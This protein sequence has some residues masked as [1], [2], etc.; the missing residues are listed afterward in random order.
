[1]G[2]K[3]ST[4]RMFNILRSK[5]KPEPVAD[6]GVEV[7]VPKETNLQNA[8][9]SVEMAIED[10]IV[11]ITPELANK[12]MAFHVDKETG[13]TVVSYKGKPVLRFG[14]RGPQIIGGEPEFFI[15][16]QGAVSA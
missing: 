6:E 16:T 2:F 3:Y 14:L 7:R 15:D 4:R 8:M 10:N 1:M 13:I 9:R 11:G 5:P 12:Y